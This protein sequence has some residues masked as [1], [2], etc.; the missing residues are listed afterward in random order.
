MNSLYYCYSYPQKDYLITNGLYCVV[1]G[2]HPKTNK[3]YWVFERNDKLD[4]LLNKWRLN[5]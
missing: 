1:K 2:I 3:K 4:N 5:K